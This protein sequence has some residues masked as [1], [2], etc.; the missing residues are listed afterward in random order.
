MFEKVHLFGGMSECEAESKRF[1][2]ISM[3]CP[4]PHRLGL[5]SNVL[6]SRIYHNPCVGQDEMYLNYSLLPNPTLLIILI[7]P[8][9][10]RNETSAYVKINYK[11][12][13]LNSLNVIIKTI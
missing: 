8:I 5:P 1:Q 7:L 4:N 13:D 9:T 10:C 2:E 6:V 12:K 11:M 3:I